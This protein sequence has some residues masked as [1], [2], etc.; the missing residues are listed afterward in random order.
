MAKKK[1]GNFDTQVL[2]SII[3]LSVVCLVALGVY[4]L[5]FCTDLM[6]SKWPTTLAT[7][8]D[9]STEWAQNSSPR[10]RRYLLTRMYH[11]KVQDSYNTG[12]ATIDRLSSAATT[13]GASP[14]G[15]LPAAIP[16][17]YNPSYTQFSVVYPEKDLQDDRFWLILLFALNVLV[18]II[19]IAS[20]ENRKLIAKAWIAQMTDVI[21]K[22]DIN[23]FHRSAPVDFHREPLSVLQQRLVNGFEILDQ[24]KDHELSRKELDAAVNKPDLENDLAQAVSALKAFYDD[25]CELYDEPLLEATDNMSANDLRVLVDLIRNAEDHIAKGSDEGADDMKP[26]EAES[27]NFALAKGAVQVMRRAAAIHNHGRYE[28]FESKDAPLASI[29]PAAIRQGHTGNCY[30]LAAVCSMAATSPQA[31]LKMI[32]ENDDGSCTVTFHGLT[33]EPI[34]VERPTVVELAVFARP[35][36]YGIW[37]AV[38]EKAY[39]IYLQSTDFKPATVAADNYHHQEPMSEVFRMLTG[40]TGKPHR[41]SGFTDDILADGLSK[42]FEEKRLVVLASQTHAQ[43]KYTDHSKLPT[44]HAY[45]VTAWDAETR[46]ATVCN[47]W[48]FM[49]FDKSLQ[50][51]EHIKY[52]GAGIF[53]MNVVQLL[54]NCDYVYLEDW[55]EDSNLIRSVY[56][57]DLPA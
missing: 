12:S 37:P 55:R 42:A 29:T 48:G 43:K 3:A 5:K 44:R 57:K 16:I 21:A 2:S 15:P 47:P 4:A 6:I 45:G 8:N 50:E 56:T 17:H 54:A 9:A 46:T 20:L 38:L 35:T 11:Y 41:L 32:H 13:I 26:S 34:T 14:A 24:N 39:G 53:A 25:I 23:I 30:F 18:P 33:D 27:T 31:I 28:L 51:R 36:R 19:G 7:L 10:S 1:A 22:N 49:P 52:L 40:Q